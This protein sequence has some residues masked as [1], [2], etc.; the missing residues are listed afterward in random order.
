MRSHLKL[1]V[2]N[3]TKK[4]DFFFIKEELRVILNLYARMVSN[5]TWK[6]YGLTLNSKEVSFDVYQRASDKPIFKILKTLKPQ[7]N[8]EKFFLKDKDGRII[9]KDYKLIDLINKTNWKKIKEG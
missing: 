4:K 7:K 2:N 5:G 3:E 6:D 8:Y 1:I 9:K